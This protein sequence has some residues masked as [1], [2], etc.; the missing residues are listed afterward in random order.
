MECLTLTETPKMRTFRPRSPLQG[1]SP[2]HR[3]KSESPPPRSTPTPFPQIKSP[4]FTIRSPSPRFNVAERLSRFSQSCSDLLANINKDSG[5]ADSS[6]S[7]TKKDQ[8]SQEIIEEADVSEKLDMSATSVD[9]IKDETAS[10]RNAES[11]HDLL[12]TADNVSQHKNFERKRVAPHYDRK[13]WEELTG[14]GS[15][16]RLQR[17]LSSEGGESWSRTSTGRRRSRSCRGS[18]YDIYHSTTQSSCIVPPRCITPI[19]TTNLFYSN[20][21]SRPVT[22]VDSSELLQIPSRSPSPEQI[23]FKK[24]SPPRTRP[25]MRS[26]STSPLKVNFE[27]EEQP[28]T[29]SR[30][31]SPAK[32]PLKTSTPKPHTREG[33]ASPNSSS[34][35]TH[36]DRSVSPY[37][38]SRDRFTSLHNKRKDP[39]PQEKT[40][41]RSTSME[42]MKI[43]E[44][45]TST[46]LSGNKDPRP[47]S[48]Y[49]D[50]LYIPGASPS[51]TKLGSMRTTMLRD[52]TG[53]DSDGEKFTTAN[54]T[55]ENEPAWW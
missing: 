12:T 25:T 14:E 32:A 4:Q 42:N 21:P 23:F 50:M 33:S 3:S 31:A 49:D 19:N 10:F 22:P 6:T 55:P 28:D 17:N 13:K 38:F 41:T 52:W 44:Q 30:C 43:N 53:Y 48:P 20:V 47:T 8:D 35:R 46:T 15:R 26:R 34:D 39:T 18:P 11:Y 27:R 7:L 24:P 9:P 51:P 29:C 1:K 36:L 54:T 5:V 37:D 40:K 16:G 2:P 45:P